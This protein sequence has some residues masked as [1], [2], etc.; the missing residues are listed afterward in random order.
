MKSKVFLG[1]LNIGK[2]VAQHTS[3]LV[4]RYEYV[5]KPVW[6]ATFPVQVV[7][8]LRVESYCN[9]ERVDPNQCMERK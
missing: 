9:L 6:P 2:S 4:N 3:K 5:L 7:L 1:F 8:E